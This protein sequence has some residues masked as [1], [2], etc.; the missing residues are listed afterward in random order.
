MAH[1]RG[2][3]IV[4]GEPVPAIEKVAAQLGKRLG[5]EHPLPSFKHLPKQTRDAARRFWSERAWS[6]YAALPVVSQIALRMAAESA[7]LAEL[8]GATAIL[9]DEALHTALSVNVAEAMGG[10]I[11]DIPDELSFDALALTGPIELP[12]AVWLAVGCCVGETVSRALIQ[13][14]LAR[15]TEPHLHAL[16]ARTLRDENLHVAFGWAA[17]RSAIS[18]LDARSKRVLA[19]QSRAALSGMYRG[20]A[21]S[22]LSGAFGRAER[23]LRQRVADAG[24]GCCAPEEEDAAVAACVQN[25]IAPNFRKLGVPFEP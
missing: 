7:S 22:G 15:T 3:A 20:P 5:A 11:S 18:G 12:R 4:L 16:V 2:K 19:D 24:L 17:A 23:K 8:G 14:R 10:Y 13:A 1:A 6:E 21:T 9:Q 25:F